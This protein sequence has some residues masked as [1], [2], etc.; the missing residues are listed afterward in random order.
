MAGSRS[1][2]TSSRGTPTSLPRPPAMKQRLCVAGLALAC[3]LLAHGQGFP[4]HY[5]ADAGGTRYAPLAQITPANVTDLS[6]AWTYRSG[7]IGKR[8]ERTM[9]RSKFQVPPI[10]AHGHLV[11]CTPFNQVAAR[12]PGPD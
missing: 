3:A 10:L 11:V 2:P 4:E 9:P 7:D 6:V 1:A 12:D 8:T 5:G